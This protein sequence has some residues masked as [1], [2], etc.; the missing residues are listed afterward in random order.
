MSKT[1]NK[2]SL[3]VSSQLPDFVRQDHQL[4]VEFLEYYYKA[5]EQDGEMLYVS[6]RFPELLD[7][8]VITDDIV[9]D[10]MEEIGRAHV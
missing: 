7:I 1:N 8:D 6:K 3:L 4:F 2:T 10:K 9:Y 5:L